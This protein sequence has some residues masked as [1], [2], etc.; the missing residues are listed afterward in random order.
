M[1][2]IS[3]PQPQDEYRKACL[4]FLHGCSN[5]VR[6]EPELCS[7]CLAAFLKHIK[8]LKDNEL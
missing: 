5:T 2:K 4:I 6:K 8:N 7:E 1:I 3:E